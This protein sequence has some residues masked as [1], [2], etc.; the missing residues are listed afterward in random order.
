[1]SLDVT[2]LSEAL[3]RAMSAVPVP[4]QLAGAVRDLLLAGLGARMRTDGGGRVPPGLVDLMR[5]LDDAATGRL[6]PTFPG[7]H[8]FGRQSMV[9]EIGA[10]EFAR[11]AG[12]PRQTVTRLCRTGVLPARRVGRVWLI[13]T[14]VEPDVPPAHD[15]AD[16]GG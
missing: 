10:P 11:R 16:P 14:N 4:T 3:E 12:L 1:M 13:T 5:A 7:E 15:T 8:T 9:E 2:A 6:R